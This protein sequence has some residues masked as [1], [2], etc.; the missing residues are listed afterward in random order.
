M[1]LILA[2]LFMHRKLNTCRIM[3]ARTEPKLVSLFREKGSVCCSPVSV[4]Y[5]THFTASTGVPFLFGK[6][7]SCS[8]HFVMKG[9]IAI[10][11]KEAII[12]HYTCRK[13]R[14]I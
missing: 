6:N 1:S 8:T 2:E 9:S 3:F 5:D 4:L 12:S 13:L 10:L 11:W 14:N 7:Q